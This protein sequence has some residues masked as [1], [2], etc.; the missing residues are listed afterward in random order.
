MRES[1]R[2]KT[3]LDCREEKLRDAARLDVDEVRLEEC[4]GGLES[5]AAHLDGA[6]VGQLEQRE[7]M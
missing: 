1:R 4:L 3:N 5:L 2:R 6:A 7:K